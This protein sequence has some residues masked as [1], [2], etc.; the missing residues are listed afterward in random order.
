MPLSSS[1]KNSRNI[2]IHVAQNIQQKILYFFKNGIFML[3]LL[4]SKGLNSKRG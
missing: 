2:V 3:C 1:F 4:L